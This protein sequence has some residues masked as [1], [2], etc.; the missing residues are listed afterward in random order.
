[1]RKS[2]DDQ[3]SDADCLRFLFWG[4]FVVVL[5][6]YGSK[7]VAFSSFSLSTAAEAIPSSDEAAACRRRPVDIGANSCEAILAEVRLPNCVCAPV[8]PSFN[9]GQQNNGMQ[10]DP[11]AHHPLHL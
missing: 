3:Q 7:D 11:K 4:Y 10:K 9:G 1:M 8:K 6:C 2:E 5:W